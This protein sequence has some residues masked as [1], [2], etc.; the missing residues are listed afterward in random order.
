MEGGSMIGALILGLVIGTAIGV[1][2]MTSIYKYRIQAV[3]LYLKCCEEKLDPDIQAH[4][5][6]HRMV[7]E[8]RK[9]FVEQ[10][11]DL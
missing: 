3:D 4:Y 10:F 6:A 11:G 8:A 2:M 7:T 9:I 1:W 5:L